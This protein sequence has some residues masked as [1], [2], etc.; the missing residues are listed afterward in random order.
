MGLFLQHAG[1]D[2]NGVVDSAG[3]NISRRLNF[4]QKRNG[5][6]YWMTPVRLIRLIPLFLLLTS[7]WNACDY[8]PSVTHLKAEELY[9]GEDLLEGVTMEEDEAAF[10]NK[11]EKSRKYERR[12]YF[13][14]GQ[15]KLD[16][17]I[18]EAK[19]SIY[20][21]AEG[22]YLIARVYWL[23]AGSRKTVKYFPEADSTGNLKFEGSL[24]TLHI[25]EVVLMKCLMKPGTEKAIRKPTPMPSI[26]GIDLRR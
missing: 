11:R 19:P 7:S 1:M 23:S 2:S 25:P 13:L 4:R 9:N 17:Y 10:I 24:S 22:K 3:E 6:L 12:R 5:Y 8:S 14:D 26:I 20:R 16:E 21:Q 18:D 15:L